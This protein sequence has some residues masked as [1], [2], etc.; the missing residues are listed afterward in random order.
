MIMPSMRVNGSP[1]TSIRSANVPES[2]SSKLQH[3]NFWSAGVSSTVLPLDAGREAGAA[4][5]AQARSRSTSSTTCGGDSD[6]ARRR[7]AQPP[8][9][10]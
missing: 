6:S 5:A 8:W 1:S 10:A 2:P 4:A 9:A 7:P 3:T